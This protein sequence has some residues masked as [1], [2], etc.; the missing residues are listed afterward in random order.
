MILSTSKT[1]EEVPELSLEER[2]EIQVR[3]KRDAI[4]KAADSEKYVFKSSSSKTR[5]IEF[6]ECRLEIWE[7]EKDKTFHG[8]RMY[9]KTKVIL[10]SISEL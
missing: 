3:K 7:G 10:N 2:Q 1:V 4:K 9:E 8:K 6:L 5:F